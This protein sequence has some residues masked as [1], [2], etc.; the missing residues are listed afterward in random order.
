MTYG[1]PLLCRSAAALLSLAILEWSASPQTLLSPRYLG[2]NS[3]PFWTCSAFSLSLLLGSP[4]F[5]FVSAIVNSAVINSGV[6]TSLAWV[7]HPLEYI[8][9]RGFLGFAALLICTFCRTS[10][11]CPWW[12]ESRSPFLRTLGACA[13]FCLSGHSRWYGVWRCLVLG[14]FA[15]SSGQWCWVFCHVLVGHLHFLLRTVC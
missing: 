13:S 5:A 1:H 12:A 10:P 9:R 6:Q 7:P 11:C 3:I 4:G 14:L 2:L 8:P 15:V